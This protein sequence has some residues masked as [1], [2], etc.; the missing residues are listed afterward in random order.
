MA[1]AFTLGI[2]EAGQ[3]R[4]EFVPEH[5]DY[6]DWFER[7]LGGTGRAFALRPY[8]AHDGV[9]PASA[10]ECDGYLI[11]GSRLSV[12]EKAA[13]MDTTK[14][15][16]RDAARSRPVVGI[17]FGHQL[18]AEAYGGRVEPSPCGWCVGVHEY[19][20]R[21]AKPW[22]APVE[23]RVSLINSN[24]DQVLAPPPD[25]EVIGTHRD[26]PVAMLQIGDN[27]LTM[28]AHPEVTPALMTDV[29]EFRR[30]QIGESKADQAIASLQGPAH[31]NLVA[32][33][34]ANFLQR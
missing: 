33:W 28:Q 4:A 1:Q 12:L 6:V 8:A 29:Y 7:A 24:T 15:F 22:M 10:D 21:A 20:I 2:L 18:I 11:T 23:T 13:W 16:V 14:S 3:N 31:S 32:G 5:G 34:V 27:V 30:P 17:C 25:A 9:L 26:V 19:E